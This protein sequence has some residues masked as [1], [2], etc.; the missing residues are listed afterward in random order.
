MKDEGKIE[1]GWERAPRDR[2]GEGDLLTWKKLVPQSI[3]SYAA[4]RCN[5]FRYLVRSET[6]FINQKRRGRREE[7]YRGE[8]QRK[9]KRYSL[10]EIYI[11]VLL[12]P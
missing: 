8:G 6:E 1:R 7:G 12:L 10:S 5:L 9:E 3:C 4:T 11:V 2:G